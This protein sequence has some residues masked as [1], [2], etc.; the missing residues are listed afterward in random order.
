V[1]APAGRGGRMNEN[2]MAA[3]ISGGHF[4]VT[5]A[6]YLSRIFRYF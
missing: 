6:A 2:A 1:I 3:G 4:D 5:D